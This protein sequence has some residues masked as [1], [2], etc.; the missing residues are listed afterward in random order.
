MYNNAGTTKCPKC[1]AMLLPDSSFCEVCGEPL[2]AGPAL[3]TQATYKK[4]PKCGSLLLPDSVFCEVCGEKLVSEPPRS[5]CPNCGAP[6]ASGSKRCSSCGS[7][8]VRCRTCNAVNLKNNDYCV[9]C[10]AS[11][12]EED[13]GDDPTMLTQLVT[14]SADEARRGCHKTIRTRK[15]DTVNIAVPPYTN[16]DTYV[17]VD[18]YGL[19]DGRGG[20]GKLRV[21]FFV[22]R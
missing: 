4:C 21:T 5:T 19:P 15:G 13:E 6:M 20:R 10:G 11:L 8:I 17:D 16:A 14:I 3:V 1:G 12:K 7:A 9:V 18:G 22:A 2:G